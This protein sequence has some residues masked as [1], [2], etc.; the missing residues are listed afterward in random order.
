MKDTSM[1]IYYFSATGNSLKVAQDIAR[2]NKDTELIPMGVNTNI[3]VHPDSVKVGFVFPVYM[4]VLPAIV[5]AFIQSF[6]VKEN[7]YYFSVATCYTY[8]G[9]AHS[10]V[11]RILKEKG[12]SLSY[13]NIVSTVGTCLK[14]YEVP[15]PKREKLLHKAARQTE[16]IATDIK[17]GATNRI[18][19]GYAWFIRLHE[20][21][22][23]FFFK[24]T[25]G[26]FVVDKGCV[27]CGTCKKVCP[28][29]NISLKEGAPVWGNRCE[30][31]HACVHWCPRNVIHLGKSKGRLTYHHP[32]ITLKQIT[33]GK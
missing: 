7:V 22:F 12:A 5:K 20:S 26:Q 19:K 1:V 21:M 14:E 25:P 24:D 4:G 18:P 27:G 10:A 9:I 16:T 8:K 30:S 13:G 33:A 32:D 2:V 23:R 28:V 15:Q 17:D 11:N 3:H 31:C 29:H 6:P